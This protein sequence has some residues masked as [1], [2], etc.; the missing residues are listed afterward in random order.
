MNNY[1]REQVAG[2]D[3][4]PEIQALR[5]QICIMP[6]RNQNYKATAA[7]MSRLCLA[8]GL[9]Y[10]NDEKPGKY[11]N[12]RLDERRVTQALS[13]HGWDKEFIL[14][15]AEKHKNL[16]RKIC[17]G[18]GGKEEH[19]CLLP[20]LADTVFQTLSPY[21]RISSLKKPKTCFLI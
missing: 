11:G 12:F 18:N 8:L 6:Q 5:A 4:D 2:D 9:Y 20:D 15:R 17:R 21:E 7:R 3:N 10:Q 1:R 16:G 13:S 19:F 14:S